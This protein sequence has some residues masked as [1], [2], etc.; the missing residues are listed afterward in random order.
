MC[1]LPESNGNFNVVLVYDLKPTFQFFFFIT[2]D[3]KSRYIVNV[4]F[5][6]CNYNILNITGIQIL[7]I[8]FII[9]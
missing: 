7:Y 3:L 2:Q 1:I 4:Y 9:L 5:I 8:I 6:L